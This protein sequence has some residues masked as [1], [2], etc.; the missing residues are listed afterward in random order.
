VRKLLWGSDPHVPYHDERAFELFLQVGSQLEPDII[1]LGGDFM[2]C[3]SVSAHRRDPQRVAF[4]DEEALE[5]NAVLDPVDALGAK[6]K[7]FIFGNHEDRLER[8]LMDKCPELIGVKGLSIVEILDLEQRGWNVV[9]Y[10]DFVK[11]GKVTYTH[12]LDYAGKYVA[13]RALAD[14][15]H[16]VV[17]GHSHRVGYSV[18]GDVAGKPRVGCSFGWLGDSAR[19]DYKHRLK[20][21]R[22]WSLGFGVGYL[23]EATG[24]TYFTPVPIIDGTCVF[25]GELF[26][27]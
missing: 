14:A 23:D 12:D 7:H 18:E 10:K 15:G 26:K 8:Y 4:L 16:S 17:V 11:I 2:D 25:E 21:N 6:E 5:A 22:D 24:T 27:A 19:A 9:P 20:A 3:Y 1:V 13:Q